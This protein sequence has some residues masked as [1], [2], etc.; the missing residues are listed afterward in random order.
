MLSFYLNVK[1][2]IGEL[3]YNVFLLTQSLH[4]L[5]V[6]FKKIQLWILMKPQITS[7]F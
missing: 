3:F 4:H 5:N 7:R 6:K 1:L 2:N